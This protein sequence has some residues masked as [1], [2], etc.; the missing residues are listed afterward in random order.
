MNSYYIQLIIELWILQFMIINADIS[1]DPK[2]I[3]FGQ[4]HPD[5]S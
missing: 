3:K 4:H 1:H 5:D 2:N